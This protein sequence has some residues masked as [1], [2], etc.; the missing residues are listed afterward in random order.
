MFDP[1]NS[2]RAI[3]TFIYLLLFLLITFFLYKLFSPKATCFD[4]KQNQN[5]KGIDCGGNCDPCKNI[6]VDIRDI[7][8]NEKEFI[9]GRNNIYDALVKITNPNNNVGA[10]LFAYTILLKD[11][12]GN[13]LSKNEGSEFILP[14]ET[15]YITAVNMS[16]SEGSI[17]SDVEFSITEI[18][19]ENFVQYQKPHFE[20]YGK[21]FGEV[22]DGIEMEA[23]GIL[24]NKS[25]FDFNKIKINIIL[26]DENGKLAALNSTQINTIRS[27][28][29]RDFKVMWPY[30][31]STNIKNMEVEVE[32]DI[33][34]NQNFMKTN[35]SDQLLPFQK[36]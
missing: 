16:V 21:R 12:N 34:D 36:L 32:A 27:E 19:W 11:G 1:R 13:I 18:K 5:E 10:S 29:E 2:K 20:I 31:L 24:K 9:Y 14:T 17:P 3:I 30:K 8:V 7:V 25:G 22:Q 28:E 35:I 23:Y 33:Y 6:A 26:R 4:G 15:K